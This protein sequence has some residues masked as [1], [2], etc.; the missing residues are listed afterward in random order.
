MTSGRAPSRRE[1]RLRLLHNGVA[2]LST[3]PGATTDLEAGAADWESAQRTAKHA[4]RLGV[5]RVGPKPP[6]CF[7]RSF[8]GELSLIGF[9]HRKSASRKDARAAIQTWLA[10]SNAMVIRSPAPKRR[11]PCHIQDGNNASRPGFGSTSFVGA[12][13]ILSCACGSPSVR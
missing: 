11:V 3:L 12:R 9:R 10:T 1:D 8:A 5:A 6:A 7:L 2:A 13:S 4:V